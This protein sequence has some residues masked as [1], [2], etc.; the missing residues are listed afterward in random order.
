MK[1]YNIEVTNHC[2]ARCDYC[3]QPGMKREK[4]FM[5]METYKKVLNKQELDFMELHGFGEPLLHPK[6]FDFVRMAKKRGFKTRFSTNGILLNEEV[7]DKLV[8]SGLDLM[9]ISIRPFFDAVKKK[10]EKLYEEYSKRIEIIVY[11]VEYPEK[12]RPLPREWYVKHIT[13]HTWSM[14]IIGLPFVKHNE[15]CFNLEN[16]AVVVLWDGRI[17]NCC[18][19]VD[20]RYI[21]GT[22]DDDKLEP[23]VIDL[24]KGC[25]FYGKG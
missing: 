19:D 23:K 11:Y 2:N 8:D 3:P 25:E 7:M 22:I 24:C 13:P 9:W 6:I 20:G 18:H 10:L 15:R 17:S 14:Q 21:L 1:I 5:S 4:G 16:R 12:V